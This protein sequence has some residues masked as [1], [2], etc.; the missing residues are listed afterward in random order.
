MD[1]GASISTCLRV[2]TSRAHL[3]NTFF[4]IISYDGHFLG[5]TYPMYAIHSLCFG[6]RIPVRF[7]YVHL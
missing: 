5:L 2:G 6:H 7:D 4:D 3:F 1:R